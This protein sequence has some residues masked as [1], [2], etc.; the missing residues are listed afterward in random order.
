[1]NGFVLYLLFRC[2][3]SSAGFLALTGVIAHLVR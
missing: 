1:M 2:L 3:A